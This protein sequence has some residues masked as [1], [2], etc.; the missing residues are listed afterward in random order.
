M[1]RLGLLMVFCALLTACG[2]DNSSGIPVASVQLNLPMT[3]PRISKLNSIGGAVFLDLNQGYTGSVAGLVLYHGSAGIVAF[4]R[5]SSYQPELKHAVV[6][7]G[8]G[9]NAL[10]T[11]SGSKFSLQDGSPVK[12][13]ATKSLRSY[14]V[15]VD[16]AQVLHVTN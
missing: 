2:K 4:D 12:A 9:F 10:D 14:Y 16:G 3:D 1:K 7:D 13:P 8:S 11:Y 5:C 15:Y 6:S